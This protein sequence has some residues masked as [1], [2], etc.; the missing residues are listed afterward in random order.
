[1]AEIFTIIAPVFLIMLL[2]FGLGK[3]KLFPENASDT[4]VAFVWNVAIPA[5]MFR[6]MASKELPHASEMLF[7]AGYYFS[8]YIVYAIAYFSGRWLFGFTVAEGAVFSIATCFANGAFLGIP[9]V[10]GAYGHEGVRLLLMLLGFHSL[11]LIPITTMIVEGASKTED[12]PGMWSRTFASIRQNPILLAL[13]TALLWSALALPFPDWLD[14]VLALPAMAASPVGLFA[15]GLTLANVEIAGNHTH[16]MVAVTL[17]L[18]FL[19][20]IVFVFTR[21]AM[22]LPDLWVA[23]ATLFACL[24]TGMIAYSFANRYG[25]G[26]RRAATTVLVST[27]FS[28]LTI[29]LVLLALHALLPNAGA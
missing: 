19:P 24:P 8:L 29:A 3:T 23:V 17:K 18:V 9:L 4:L 2:G 12:G 7:V 10:E 22:H 16:S 14:K 26:A 13:F 15:V 6:A 27:C 11:T 5:L 25:V 28:V 21:Y 1:M 20:F